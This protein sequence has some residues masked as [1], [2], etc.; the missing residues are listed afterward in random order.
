MLFVIRTRSL[1]TDDGELIKSLHCPLRMRGA[2][3]QSDPENRHLFCDH[4]SKTVHDTA[5]LSEVETAQL[6]REDPEA[7]LAIGPNQANVT[8]V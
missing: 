6:V 1:Y 2:D 4:C 7:C 8:V 3:L 5:L